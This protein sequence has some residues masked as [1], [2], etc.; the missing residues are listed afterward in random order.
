[1]LSSGKRTRALAVPPL[2]AGRPALSG[3]LLLNGSW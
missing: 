3:R 2:L 1:M